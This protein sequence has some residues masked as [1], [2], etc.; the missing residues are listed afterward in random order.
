[1]TDGWFGSYAPGV[2][3]RRQVS[4]LRLRPRFQPDL[5]RHGVEPRLPRHGPHL[6]RDAGEGHAVAVQA[7][8]RRERGED[9]QGRGPAKKD[10]KEQGRRRSR[11]TSTASRTAL[12]RLAD[13][14]GELSQSRSRSATRSTTSATG[15]K[16][17]KPAFQST[18]WPRGR[19][20]ALGSVNGYEISADGKKMLVSQGRQVRHHRSAEGAGHRRRGAQPV[21]PGDEARSPEGMAADLPRVLA[22]DARLLLRSRTCTASTGRRCAR[23]YEPLLA[24]VN[25]RADLT[26]VIG[27]MIG[28]LN[29]GPCLRRRR[30]YAASAAHPRP[31]CSAPSCRRT[32]RPATTRSTRSSRAPP[33]TRKPALAAD[34]DR[35]RRRAKAI[36]SSPSTASRP[37]RWSTSTK[38]CSTRP[39]SR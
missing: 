36:T 37:T 7:A 22:A 18:T 13:S 31:A 11:S 5:Q 3:R 14:G 17:A 29:V 1:M 12:L 39:A 33:G 30:R 2:Q 26:Y 28:E 10:P 38:R 24:H 25:H 35:R 19:R 15:S 27:E 9:A 23:S 8:Q 32:R 20:P 21:R 4:V 6:L 16:D 34:R